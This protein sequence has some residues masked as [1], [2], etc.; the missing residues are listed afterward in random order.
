MP[1]YN[2]TSKHRLR[3]LPGSNMISDIDA[4]IQALA[5]DVDSRMASVDAGSL[6]LRPTSTPGTPGV[7]GRLYR[8]TDESNRIDFDYGTGW[9]ALTAEAE[10]RCKVGS[11]GNAP[12]V[13]GWGAYNLLPGY[14]VPWYLK[15]AGIVHMGGLAQRYSGNSGFIFTLPAGFRPESGLVCPVYCGYQGVRGLGR[16]DIGANG[17]VAQTEGPGSEFVSLTSI[18]FRAVN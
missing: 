1:T 17:S 14:E 6:A 15:H 9:I 11:P 18:T 16:I 10:L 3:W 8:V 4:G 5:E 2:T 13:A 7:L 12:F